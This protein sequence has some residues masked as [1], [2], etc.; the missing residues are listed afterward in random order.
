MAWTG[1]PRD[2]LEPSKAD[3]ALLCAFWM[4]WLLVSLWPWLLVRCCVVLLCARPRSK[5][6]GFVCICGVMC[7]ILSSNHQHIYVHV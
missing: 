1:L 7:V 2:C 4:N 6:T 3:V 5:R